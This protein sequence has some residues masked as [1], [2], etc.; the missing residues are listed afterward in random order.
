M[1]R[2]K[3]TNRN[4]RERSEWV[5][6][7]QLPVNQH[8]QNA[9][10]ILD[11]VRHAAEDFAQAETLARAKT[12]VRNFL[13]QSRSVTWALQHLKGEMPTTEWEAWWA[14]T[15]APLHT[16]PAA[17]WFYKLRNPIV[18]E[19]QPVEIQHVAHLEGSIMLPPPNEQRPEGA[20]GYSLDGAM[21]PWWNMADGSRL[22]AA[23]LPNVRRWHT[24]A[25]IPDELA[26]RPLTDHMS[27]YIGVLEGIVAAAKNRFRTVEK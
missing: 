24:L 10:E 11:A 3:N 12:A 18:K 21:F 5:H 8:I 23:P 27:E 14:A 6:S 2:S 20:T 13:E 16:D 7:K 22:P 25:G 19:G 26:R 15:T 9:E 1:A 4:R 17:Q